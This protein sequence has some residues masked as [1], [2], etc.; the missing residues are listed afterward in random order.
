MPS[1]TSSGKTTTTKI[2]AMTTCQWVTVHQSPTRRTS[3]P[4]ACGPAAVDSVPEATSANPETTE[5]SDSGATKRG[6]QLA[7]WA[8]HGQAWAHR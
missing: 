2:V 3:S 5:S 1:A 6:R 4:P 8:G 7:W